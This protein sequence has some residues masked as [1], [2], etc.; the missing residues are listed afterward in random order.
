MSL[1]NSQRAE[2]NKASARAFLR[3]LEEKRI[4]A[5]ME[6]W[7]ED[8]EHFYPFGRRMFPEHIVGR[9][10]IHARWRN[11]PQ[12]FRRLSFPV[13]GM[14]AEGDTVIVQFDGEC[15]MHSGDIYRNT[16]ISLLT[17]DDNGKIR[18]YAEY[19]DPIEAGLGFGLLDV[20]YHG[21]G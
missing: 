12:T 2:A 21:V 17:F 10:A 7:A 15:V 4:D 5:W 6:L 14:W 1:A 19:F 3:L 9:D 13:R 20:D 8:A 18:L 11:L 16:Y